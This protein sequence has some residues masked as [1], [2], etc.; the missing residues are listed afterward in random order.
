MVEILTKAIRM[1]T[2]FQINEMDIF[3]APK[4]YQQLYLAPILPSEANLTQ[5]KGAYPQG[6]ESE[7]QEHQ[8]LYKRLF[9]RKYLKEIYTQM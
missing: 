1:K 6:F 2:K 7:E 5:Q 3:A 4:E 9:V 8:Y